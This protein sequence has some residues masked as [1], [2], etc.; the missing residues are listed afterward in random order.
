MSS[1][2]TE[3]SLA[4]LP[5]RGGDRDDISVHSIDDG[6]GA[7]TAGLTPKVGDSTPDGVRGSGLETPSLYDLLSSS[8]KH[9]AKPN[10]QSSLQS[11]LYDLC[12]K[13]T[14]RVIF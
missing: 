3:V 9:T 11:H 13:R 2:S 12:E 7:G 1:S 4:H 8:Q 5:L 10:T 6:V 14:D